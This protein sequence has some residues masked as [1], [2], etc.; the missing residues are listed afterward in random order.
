MRLIEQ[1]VVHD[2]D[3]VGRRAECWQEAEGRGLTYYQLESGERI[4][5]VDET[6]FQ[7]VSDGELL[8]RS[9]SKGSPRARIDS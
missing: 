3:S 4:L 5:L 7:R 1:F 8:K 9:L 6:T 2:R